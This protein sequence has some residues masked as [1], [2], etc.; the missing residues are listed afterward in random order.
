M[1]T[2]NQNRNKKS[3]FKCDG[4]AFDSLEETEFYMFLRDCLKHKLIDSFEYQPTPLVL[5][6]KAT[7]TIKTPYVKKEGYKITQKTLYSEHKYTPD[8]KFKPNSKFWNAFPQ[9]RNLLRFSDVDAH[10]YIDVKGAYNRF[11]GDR[12]FSIN[13]KLVFR[14]HKVHINKVIPQLFFQKLGAAPD[15]IRWMKSR[16]VPTLRKPYIGVKSIEEHLGESVDH[17]LENEEINVS[18]LKR[19]K[20]AKTQDKKDN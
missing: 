1:A 16:K 20:N 2:L 18:F 11:G 10:Y 8:F 15:D 12:Q 3:Q 7:I 13:Q 6:P 5:I 17:N 14:E 9:T 19:R 4:Y